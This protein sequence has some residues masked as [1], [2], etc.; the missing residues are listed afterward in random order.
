M[1]TGADPFA[2]VAIA[3]TQP[4]AAVLLSLFEW[5]GIPAYAHGIEMVRA[6]APMTLAMGGIPIRV[7]RDCLIDARALLAQAAD[8]PEPAAVRPAAKRATSGAVALLC[9][10]LGGVSPPPRAAAVIVE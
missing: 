9:F 5:H 8:D 2:T 10:L 7:R 3:Y 1:D 6:N 4:Q